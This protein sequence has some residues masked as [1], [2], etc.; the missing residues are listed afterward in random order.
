MSAPAVPADH[1]RSGSPSSTGEPHPRCAWCKRFVSR[2]WPLTCWRVR[3]PEPNRQRVH[4]PWNYW[5]RLL[6]GQCAP[7]TETLWR[8]HATLGEVVDRRPEGLPNTH[9]QWLAPMMDS[10]LNVTA[11]YLMMGTDP[12]ERSRL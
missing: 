5:A 7:L 1:G 3:V 11:P 6:C 9:P 10:P 12:H 4:D 8:K 2:S